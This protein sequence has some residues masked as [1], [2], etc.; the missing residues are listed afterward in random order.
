MRYVGG[1]LCTIKGNRAR[2][3]CNTWRVKG[4]E[5]TRRVGWRIEYDGCIR[6]CVAC[7]EGV[8]VCVHSKEMMHCMCA[9]HGD[10]KVRRLL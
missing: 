9:I 3:V 7:D 6:I 10:K 5:V 1:G 2:Y 4:G 8:V